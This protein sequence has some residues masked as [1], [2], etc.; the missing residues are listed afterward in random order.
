MLRRMPGQPHPGQNA[1]MV[2]PGE[3]KS[4]V[5]QFGDA[6]IVELTCHA[7]D[8]SAIALLATVLVAP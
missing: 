4:I 2:P 7:L 6:P 1:L 3:T 8:G 5:W